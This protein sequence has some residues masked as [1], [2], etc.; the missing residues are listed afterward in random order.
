MVT[1]LAFPTQWLVIGVPVIQMSR[2]KEHHG[3]SGSGLPHGFDP[4]VAGHGGDLNRHAR[5]ALVAL[6][7]AA[8]RC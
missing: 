5:V 2:V 6:V 1:T 4:V 7:V 3:L 8:R